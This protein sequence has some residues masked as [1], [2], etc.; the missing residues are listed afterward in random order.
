MLINRYGY[1]NGSN[2]ITLIWKSRTYS[3]FQMVGVARTSICVLFV[4]K[5]ALRKLKYSYPI[6]AKFR[7]VPIQNLNGKHLDLIGLT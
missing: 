4:Y 3:I 7:Y 5:D 2:H 6:L 1:K